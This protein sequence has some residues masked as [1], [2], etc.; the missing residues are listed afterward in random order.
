MNNK[1]NI[2]L[3]EEKTLASVNLTQKVYFCDLE[4]NIKFENILKAI[5]RCCVV[6]F[7]PNL[8]TVNAA[9]IKYKSA[10]GVLFNDKIYMLKNKSE[11]ALT[12]LGHLLLSSPAKADV[13]KFVESILQ[14][15]SENSKERLKKCLN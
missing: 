9:V 7:V 10:Y 3:I 11:I 8:V 1:Q 13:N 6:K 14:I 4:Q 2:G 12:M 15:H 5:E